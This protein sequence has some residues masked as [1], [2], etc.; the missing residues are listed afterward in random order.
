M[1]KL[2]LATRRVSLVLVPTA[3]LRLLTS[4]HRSH[5]PSLHLAWLSFELGHSQ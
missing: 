2:T 3:G 1:M 5:S 4:V